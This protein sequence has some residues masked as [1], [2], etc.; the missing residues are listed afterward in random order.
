MWRAEQSVL[1]RYQRAAGARPA[2]PRRADHRARLAA[3]GV[4]GEPRLEVTGAHQRA[5]SPERPQ[6]AVLSVGRQVGVQQLHAA[7]PGLVERP[8][9]RRQIRRFARAGDPAVRRPRHGRDQQVGQRVDRRAPAA[10]EVAA[11]RYTAGVRLDRRHPEAPSRLPPDVRSV[12][13]AL[14]RAGELVQAG[15]C[16]S[17]RGR[18]GAALGLEPHHEVGAFRE[19]VGDPEERGVDPGLERVAVDHP[20]GP[21]G[22][23]RRRRVSVDP[24]RS[25]DQRAGTREE[26]LHAGDARPAARRRGWRW[27]PPPLVRSRRGRP[28]S[29]APGWSRHGRR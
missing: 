10:F 20:G 23:L 9:V 3:L 24:Q 15:V 18:G 22:R 7:W 11:E 8:Q 1:R 28:G 12:Q 16:V 25:R 29:P 4:L 26:R 6:V 5:I 17:D 27:R 21:P 14:T 13:R 2:T 19:R